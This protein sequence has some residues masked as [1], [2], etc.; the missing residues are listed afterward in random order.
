[1]IGIILRFEIL[2]SKDEKWDIKK[3]LRRLNF[4]LG[5]FRNILEELIIIFERIHASEKVFEEQ[6]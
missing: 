4:L 1:M 6:L 2:T 3:K 5:L